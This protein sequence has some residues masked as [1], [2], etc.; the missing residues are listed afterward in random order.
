MYGILNDRKMSDLRCPQRLRVLV[1]L[2]KIFEVKHYVSQKRHEIE[3]KS[4]SKFQLIKIFLTSG[5]L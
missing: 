5:D 3:R 2:W 4:Q 1:K